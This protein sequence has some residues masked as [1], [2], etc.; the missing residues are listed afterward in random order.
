M[1]N[2]F[3]VPR[4]VI[5]ETLSLSDK[6]VIALVR[7]KIVVRIGKEY[8]LQAS[9]KNYIANLKKRNI[10]GDGAIDTAVEKARLAKAQADK[11]ELEVMEMKREMVP[12]SEIIEEVEKMFSAFRQKCLTLPSKI[13]P[14]VYGENNLAKIQSIME[15][16]TDEILNELSK[17]K[18]N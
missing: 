16:E 17:F 4:Q 13:S 7:K 5:D 12:I 10:H 3:L 2:K 8:D 11:T 6:Q 14:I 18:I 9:A 15:S 1:D